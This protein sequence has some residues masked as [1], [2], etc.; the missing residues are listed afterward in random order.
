MGNTPA[1]NKTLTSLKLEPEEFDSFKVMCVR[2]K[3]SLSKLVDRAMHLYVNDETF[4]KL[5]HNYKHEITGS[6]N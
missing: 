1:A 5:M 3:F 6:A 4:R 2:T